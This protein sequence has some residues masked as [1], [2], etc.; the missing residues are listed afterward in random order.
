M[1]Y[2]D[3]KMKYEQALRVAKSGN[4]IL[5][6][7]SG[8]SYGLESIVGHTLPTAKKLAEILCDEAGIRKIDDLKK[9]SK[10]FIENKGAEELVEILRD[11]F[12]VNK[13]SKPHEIISQLPWLRIY[14]TNYDNCFEIAAANNKIRYQSLDPDTDPKGE[15]SKKNVIH[16]NGYI[17]SLDI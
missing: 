17:N 13:T 9:A 12:I 4:A 10:R 16:I 2:V 5:F 15:I 3:K 6:L 11:Y 7:G 1:F 8:F 14:T